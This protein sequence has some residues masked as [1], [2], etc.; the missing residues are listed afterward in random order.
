MNWRHIHKLDIL[1][2]YPIYVGA[3]SYILHTELANLLHGFPGETS[4]LIAQVQVPESRMEAKAY[5][6]PHKK[7]SIVKKL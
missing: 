7:E 2:V 3:F 6:S 4:T 1:A 5:P